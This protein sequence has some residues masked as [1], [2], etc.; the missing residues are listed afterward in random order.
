MKLKKD[1]PIQIGQAFRN[2]LVENF[3]RVENKIYNKDIE[4]RKHRT[5]EFAAHNSKQIKHNKTNVEKQLNYN[6]GRTS[7]L[8]VGSDE[9]G[10]KEVIDAR[11]DREG[12]SHELLSERLL[13]DFNDVYNTTSF[14]PNIDFKKLHYRIGNTDTEY[15]LMDVPK[16]DNQGNKLKLKHGFAA[17]QFGNGNKETARTFSDRNYASAVF[18]GSVFNT[19]NFN[20]IGNQ[21][22]DGKIYQ[23]DSYTDRSY[24]WHLGFKEDGTMKIYPNGTSASTMLQDGIVN[25]ITAFYPIILN[26]EHRPDI[27]HQHA[28][29]KTFHPRQVI[30][31]R[32]N[33]DYVFLSSEGRNVKHR[34]LSIDDCY[35]ILSA[36][37][38]D[39]T[40][41]YVLDGGGSTSSVVNGTMINRPNDSSLLTERSVPDF[42]YVSKEVISESDKHLYRVM[43]QVGYVRK[44]LS[45][46]ESAV[47]YMRDMNL[48]HI[49][50]YQNAPFDQ[51]GIEVRRKENGEDKYLGKLLMND[52][53]ISY[54]PNPLS[55]GQ[56]PLFQVDK[57][58]VWFN[59]QRLGSAYHV[60]KNIDK[61]TEITYSGWYYMDKNASD[62]PYKTDDTGCYI[63]Y[64]TTDNHSGMAIATPLSNQ[65]QKRR[66]KQDDA[67]QDWISN[68]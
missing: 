29:S 20:L 37:Y 54:K 64:M 42:L 23:S 43:K 50:L 35:E 4:D 25:S 39:I 15:Y 61:I 31:Q 7:N 12:E 57:N 44:E 59:G 33:G 40:N 36:N 60:T 41:A 10:Q 21:I 27:Y 56:I 63:L 2:M 67:W 53:V 34:G 30:A 17:E 5:D 18:N 14:V 68:V 28:D 1:L 65:K 58:D 55:E 38:N 45:N 22:K 11:V 26:K 16:F 6:S 13:S 24:R 8:V 62:N 49:R 52:E 48:G 9:Y 32:E 3:N 47:L 51:Y 66:L 19:S 46:L